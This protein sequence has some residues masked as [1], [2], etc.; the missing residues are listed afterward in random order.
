MVFLKRGNAPSDED[1]DYL[2]SLANLLG[3]AADRILQEQPMGRSQAR[4][5]RLG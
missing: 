2:Q 3:V 4:R 5:S 1:K